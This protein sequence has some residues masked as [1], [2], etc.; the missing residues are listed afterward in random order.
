MEL[1]I[2][3]VAKMTGLSPSGIRFLENEGFFSPSGGRKGSYRSYSL[4]DVSTIL[5]YRNYRMCGLS[6]DEIHRL[7]SGEED[8]AI[9]DLH[10]D[11]L[12]RHLMDT[13]RLLHFLRHRRQDAVNI[14]HAETFWEITE[15]PAIIWLPLQRPEDGKPIGWP[16]YTGFEIP[17]TDSVLMFDASDVALSPC[18]CPEAKIGIGMLE[19]DV[20]NVSFLGSSNVRYFGKHTAFH[21]IVK[22]DEDFRM[23][24]DSLDVCRRLMHAAFQDC[25]PE[26]DR[27]AIAK[28]I[29]TVNSQSGS[30]RYDNLWIDV[31]K[32]S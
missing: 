1:K 24:S 22:I 11:E 19:T 23:V 30:Q 10:C 29:M 6:Q 2:G 28:R 14:Q 4:A 3:T 20:L 16:D 5:D 9:F 8:S 25:R 13:T 27:P 17:Y 18:R 32:N 15:R 21:C 31:R 7:F 12:E 26:P